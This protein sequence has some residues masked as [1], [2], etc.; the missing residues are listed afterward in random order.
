MHVSQAYDEDIA[1]S[2][3]AFWEC[4]APWSFTHCEVR[5][6]GY[7]ETENHKVYERGGFL[8][9]LR[10]ILHILVSIISL[11]LLKE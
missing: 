4:S 6:K 11:P 5:G 1:K 7:P 3:P 10:G 9:L 2:S 8:D